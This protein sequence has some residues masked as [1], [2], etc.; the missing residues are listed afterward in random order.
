VDFSGTSNYPDVSVDVNDF[1]DFSSEIV[2]L[3][4]A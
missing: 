3:N 4:L 2:M 1:V